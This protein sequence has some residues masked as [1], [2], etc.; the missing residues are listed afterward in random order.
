MIMQACIEP[1][2]PPAARFAQS[3]GAGGAH[4]S[5]EVYA[6]V[7]RRHSRR[8]APVAKGLLACAS[9]PGGV[10]RCGQGPMA[11][12]PAPA[13]GPKPEIPPAGAPKPRAELELGDW[14]RGAAAAW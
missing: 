5:G 13:P 1:A 12:R 14:G 6:R 8:P 10:P 3:A 9:R 7:W 4:D 2:L 11:T